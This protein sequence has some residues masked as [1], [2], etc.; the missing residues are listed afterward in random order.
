MP[1][2]EDRL[3]ALRTRGAS[4]WAEVRTRAENGWRRSASYVRSVPGRVGPRARRRIAWSAGVTGGALLAIV[5]ALGVMD[6]NYFKGPVERV[7][8]AR[9][10]RPVHIDGNLDVNLISWN[11]GASVEGLRIA[12]TDWAGG[13]DFVA[14][15][16]LDVKVKLLPLFKGDVVL[17]LLHV[18]KPV[19]RLVRL[20]D[21]RNN[22]T[23]GKKDKDAFSLP[24]IRRFEISNGDL[25]IDD[26][27]RRLVFRGLINSSE[28]Q[29]AERQQG[30]TL[31]GDGTLNGEAF[32]MDLI[33]G[34]LLNVDPNKPYPFDARVRAGDTQVLARGAIAR[35]FDLAVFD[36]QL[37]VKG[38]DLADLYY[39]T[40]LA[41]PNTPPYE[42][43]GALAR[44][45]LTY[46]YDGL[47]GRLGDS[48]INGRV[49]VRTGGERLYMTADLRSRRLD[50]NDL[51]AV[52]GAGARTA[53]SSDTSPEQ[54]AQA[55]QLAASGRLFPDTPLRVERLRQM[56]ADVRYAADSV[57]SRNFPISAAS[58]TAKLENGLLRLDPL[59]FDLNYGRVAGAVAINARQDIPAV[60]LDMRLSGGRIDQFIPAS[61]KGAIS[62][63]LIGRARL[64]GAGLSVRAAAASADGQFTLVIPEGQMREALAELLGVNI[65]RGLFTD[66]SETT[67]LRCAVADFKVTDGV[68][69]AQTIVFDTEPV[70]VT[71]GG[72][73]SL[74]TERMALRVKGHPK[75]PRFVRLSVPI[76]LKGPIRSPSLGV[77][78]STAVGQG[79]IAAVLAAALSPLA[80]ILPFVDPGLADDANCQALVSRA[81]TGNPAPTPNTAEAPS[82]RRKG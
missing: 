56:D 46:A 12:N 38:G 31:T 39:L 15:E 60:N 8:S 47:R 81:G 51:A 37:T 58:V 80:A 7:L 5:F 55:R 6:W 28:I 14:I 18:E 41:L 59:E 71:G 4:L 23:L 1:G 53:P 22:W 25:S 34:P 77:D 79:G 33:G 10:G 49:E 50:F 62:G 76:E 17:P 26:A 73:V 70:I 54:A 35:P 45:N 82:P 30:F 36:T 16:Q 19:V 78:P 67:A 27:Q 74:K 9:A 65:L 75:E 11:P 68:M 48:D 61:Y 52:L 13:G 20:E 64:S 40:G 66:P 44:R 21:G 72:Q 43:S 69:Q 2:L 29:E 32:D 42:V 57:N 24:P 63:P 3:K